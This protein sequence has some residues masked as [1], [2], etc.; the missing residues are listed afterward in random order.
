MLS[1]DQGF[2]DLLACLYEDPTSF[3][4]WQQFL[5]GLTGLSSSEKAGFHVHEF[6]E[7]SPR[8]HVKGQ[9]VFRVGYTHEQAELYNNQ[10]ALKDPY[11]SRIRSRFSGQLAVG[12][13]ADLFAENE[14]KK[15]AFFSEY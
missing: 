1:S 3:D 2:L 13:T 10:F 11:V 14:L 9:V 12:T 5:S 7:G 15:T 6:S 8:S 4:Q